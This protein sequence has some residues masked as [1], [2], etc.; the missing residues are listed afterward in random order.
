MV[1]LFLTVTTV[2]VGRSVM[3]SSPDDVT[4]VRDS[5]T[6]LRS[7]LERGGGEAAQQQ[8]P[9]GYFFSYA[10]YG[11][12]WTGLA[13]AEHVDRGAARSEARWALDQLDSAAGRRVFTEALK[14]SYGIFYAGWS[15][16]LRA[17]V[18]SLDES[19]LDVA[20]RDRIAADADAVAGAFADSLEGGG[21]PFLVAYPNQSWPVD[22]VVAIAAL[23][24]ADRA[25]GGVHDALIDRWIRRANELI[26]PRTGLF[27]HQTDPMTGKLIQGSRGTSQSIIQRLWPLVDPATAPDVYRRFRSEFVTTTAGLLGVREYPAGVDGAADVDSGPLVLGFSASATAVAM[28]AARANGDGELA[29]AIGHEADVFGIP[30]TIGGERRYAFG[31]VPIG[32]AFVTWARATPQVPA[33]TFPRVNATWSMYVVIPWAIVGLAWTFMWRGRARRAR[34]ACPPDRVIP[35]DQHGRHDNPHQ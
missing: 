23:R 1:T 17:D 19:A 9:E 29:V 8:F 6:F 28:G 10:L 11:L 13:Q 3:D 15:L 34:A 2:W 27:P 33:R 16:L 22:S 7:S 24:Q 14:P 21:S 20:E 5:L 31:A 32:D 25:T 12:A 35:P 30:L 4:P 18:A 26:D